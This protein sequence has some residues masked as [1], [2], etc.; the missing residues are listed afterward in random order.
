MADGGTELV[1]IQR[2]DALVVFTTPNALDPIL[3]RI[4]QEIDA[5]RPDI[6]TATGRKAIASMAYKVA[7]SKTYLDGIGKTLA[8]EQKAIPKKIDEARR[9]L[10]DTL[11]AWKDD[12]RRPLTEW[13]QAEEARVNA[14][15]AELDALRNAADDREE[16]TTESLRLWLDDVLDTDPSAA[17]WA[18]FAGDA[19]LLKD[20]AVRVLEGRLALALRREAEA[21]ELARLRAEQVVRERLEREAQAKRDAEEREHRAAE[22][23]AAAERAKAEAAIKAAAAEAERKEREHQAALAAAE[24]KLAEAE[25]AAKRKAT[26]IEAAAK[27]EA[28]RRARIEADERAR[29]QAR[30]ADVKHRAAI[31]AAARDA[32]VDIG[33]IDKAVATSVIKL[34]ASGLIPAVTINY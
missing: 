22:V 26:E 9:K 14:I 23:A 34:I 12:V 20:A 16:R 21:A 10:R 30:E 15:R 3:A 19:A 6:S 7:T 11:D 5:F 32:L 13:E 2:A 28:E 4:R 27:A 1:T 25:E 31:N 8:D 18:E 17:K 29:L 24:R 33:D